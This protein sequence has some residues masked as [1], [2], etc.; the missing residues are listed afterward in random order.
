MFVVVGFR[1]L[2]NPTNDRILSAL[3][4]SPNALDAI[5]REFR[6]EPIATSQ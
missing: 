2:E 5:L 6:A 1:S 3:Y 4:S